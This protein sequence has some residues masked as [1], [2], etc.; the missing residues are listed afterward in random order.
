[1]DENLQTKDSNATTESA[2]RAARRKLI[3]GGLSVAPIAMTLASR[4]VLAGGTPGTCTTP[5]GFTSINLKSGPDKS[6]GTCSGRTP[7]YWKQSQWFGQWPAPYYPVAGTYGGVQQQATKFGTAFGTANGTFDD[8]TLLAVLETG[9]GDD[10]ELARHI[11]AALLNAASGKTPVLSV[12]AVTNIWREYVL[13]GY[14]EPTAGIKWGSVK[15]TDYLKTTM[16][17]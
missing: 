16:P 8:M 1:M 3:K 15:T 7:G 2:Q 10:A 5:S 11:A 4:P 6:A 9:G 13:R 14:F 17:V 12:D